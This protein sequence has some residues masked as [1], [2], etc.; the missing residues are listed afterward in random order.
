M[1]FTSVTQTLALSGLQIRGL[2]DTSIYDSLTV[3][4]AQKASEIAQDMVREIFGLRG[5]PEQQI[6]NEVFKWT[7]LRN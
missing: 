6:S 4:D 1:H 7:G 2:A 3:A 5:I